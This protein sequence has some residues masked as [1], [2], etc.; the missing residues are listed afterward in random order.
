MKYLLLLGFLGVASA[1]CPE[2]AVEVYGSVE[3]T[4]CPVLVASASNDYTSGLYCRNTC[5]KGHVVIPNSVSEL[6]KEAF[7]KCD[8]MTSVS[9]P[10]GITKISRYAFELEIDDVSFDELTSVTFPSTLVEIKSLAF[11]NLSLI[12]I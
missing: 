6:A 3:S 12:H 5:P 1:S 9:L 11:Y 4:C 7:Y 10:E 8:E 2:Y